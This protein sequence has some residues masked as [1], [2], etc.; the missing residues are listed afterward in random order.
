MADVA[1]LRFKFRDSSDREF[2]HSFRY[3]KPSTT[4]TD[5]KALADAMIANATAFKKEPKSV[6]SAE[7]VVTTAT[8]IEM[9]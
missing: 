9:G 3:A 5:A 7:I 8:P 1:S 2:D 6:V 4:G